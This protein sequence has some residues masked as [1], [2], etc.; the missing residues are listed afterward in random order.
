MPL[1]VTLAALAP[2]TVGLVGVFLD[3]RFPQ[4]DSLA[5][6]PFWIGYAAIVVAMWSMLGLRA[7]SRWLSW[8]RRAARSFAQALVPFQSPQRE[9]NDEQDGRSTVLAGQMSAEPPPATRHAEGDLFGESRPASGRLALVVGE[10]RLAIEDEAALVVPTRITLA[11]EDDEVVAHHVLDDGAPVRVR[12]LLQRQDVAGGEGYR[13]SR[14]RWTLLPDPQRG[15]IAIAAD[16]PTIVITPRILLR[17]WTWPFTVAFVVACVMARTAASYHTAALLCTD[18]GCADDGLCTVTTARFRT[19]SLDRMWD[20][21]RC[22][23]TKREHCTEARICR[24]GGFCFF[25]QHM[26]LNRPFD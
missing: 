22:W 6:W 16:Q 7:L 3:R 26:C 5:A 21:F 24:E 2:T 9:L 18:L 13:G 10:Q 17:R 11:D 12:A 15:A 4:G 1:A 23:P 14:E 25:H 19:D 20:P 8:R